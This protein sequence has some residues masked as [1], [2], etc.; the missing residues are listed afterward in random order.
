MCVSQKKTSL[1]EQA[2]KIDP[3]DV[4]LR[5]DTPIKINSEV[6]QQTHMSIRMAHKH[7]EIQYP[8]DMPTTDFSDAKDMKLYHMLGI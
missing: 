2:L 4:S 6:K 5:C 7:T 1:E 3:L 8:A